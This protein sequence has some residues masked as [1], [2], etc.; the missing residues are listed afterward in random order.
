MYSYAVSLD[1][2]AGFIESDSHYIKAIDILNHILMLKPEFPQIHY[3]LALSLSHYAE[4]VNEKDLFLRAIHHYRIAKGQEGD[5]D[6]I[7][8]DWALTLVNLGD[9]LENDVESDQY[10]REAEYKMIQAAKLGNTHA[11]YALACLYSILGDLGNSLRFLEKAKEFD[12]LPTID[13]LLE[14]DWL[15]NLKETESFK[16]FIAELQHHSHE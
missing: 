11:Y 2:L 12:A 9:L 1:L 16:E 15:E 13:D 8:L 5:N 7:I 10:L 14:D 3:R 4:L 6:Q